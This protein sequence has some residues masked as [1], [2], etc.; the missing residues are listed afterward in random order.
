MKLTRFKGILLTI[1]VV[2]GI[3]FSLV[4][5]RIGLGLSV[6][7]TSVVTGKASEIQWGH[8]KTGLSQTD[9]LG[10]VR[11]T[12]VREVE[13]DE[14]YSNAGTTKKARDLEFDQ[15]TSQS[16][17]GVAITKNDQV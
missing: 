11:I 5:I 3:T 2:Q 13:Y 9:T 1:M 15:T 16:S 6:G 8:S 10:M 7:D 4:M 14:N 17:I 12:R